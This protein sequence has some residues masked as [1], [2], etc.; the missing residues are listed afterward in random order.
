MKAWGGRFAAEPDAN[1]ADFGRSIEVDAELNSVAFAKEL[2]MAL[3][4]MIEA[5]ESDEV[6][7]EAAR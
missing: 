2:A 3:H 7:S 4:R 6:D 1:A 5:H